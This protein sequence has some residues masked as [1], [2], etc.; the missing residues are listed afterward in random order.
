MLLYD[1]VMYLPCCIG[2]YI[3]VGQI[4]MQYLEGTATKI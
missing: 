2:H 4:G 3:A 1:I